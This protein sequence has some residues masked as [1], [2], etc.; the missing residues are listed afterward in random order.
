MKGKTVIVTGANRGLGLELCRQFKAAG[1]EV[2]G[3]A[4]DP[5]GAIDLRTLEVQIEPLDVSDDPSVE[6]LAERLD[7]VAIDVLV[8]NAGVGGAG[9][10]VMSLDMDRAREFFEVNTLGPIRVTRALLPHLRRGEDRKIVHISSLMGSLQEN[11]VG[12]Y[13]CYRA[14]KA[15]LNMMNRSLAAELAGQ[16]FV[17]TVCHPGWVRTRM[18]GSSAPVSPQES[19]SGLVRVVA[20]LS[21]GHNGRFFDY[22]GRELPW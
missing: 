22:T 7:G 15:A 10:G 11:S 2:I 5:R 9:N 21:K 17:C 20:G 14:S 18:G 6:T 12:G 16:G 4:R 8:N 3:T 19:A 13:Y 1:A